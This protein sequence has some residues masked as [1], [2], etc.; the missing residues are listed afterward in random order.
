[1]CIGDRCVG[2]VR[3]RARQR[4]VLSSQRYAQ[5][6]KQEVQMRLF[7]DVKLAIKEMV[8]QSSYRQLPMRYVDLSLIHIPPPT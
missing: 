3:S 4:G 7:A 1:M 6:A 2:A 5:P 8:G